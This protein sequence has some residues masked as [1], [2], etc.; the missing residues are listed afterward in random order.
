MTQTWGGIEAGG[1]HF[2]CAVGSGPDRLDAEASFP[3]TTPIETLARATAFFREDA[4]AGVGAVGIASFGPL[5]LRPDSPT[6]GHATSTPKPGWEGIDLVGTVSGALGVPVAIDTDVNASALAEHVWGAAIG[7][8]DF[9]YITVGTGI[10]GGAMA[11]GGLVHGL[12]HPEMGHMRVPHVRAV[13]DF[14]GVCPY[15]GDCLEGLASGPSIER[16]W[17]REPEKLPDDHPAWGL[18]A[19]YLAAGVVNLVCTL[20]PQRVVMGGGVMER[21]SLL[22][23]IRTK[24]QELLGGYVRAPQVLDSIDDY[25]VTPALGTRSGVLGAIALAQR[26]G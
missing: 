6:Y 25:I 15:H 24:V 4:G 23:L 22:P 11:G 3:T 18:E 16:R 5:D 8:T 9:V 1:T 19:S 26:A 13:D 20:S 17:G 12:V 21:P 2:V 7:L 14:D 10:G